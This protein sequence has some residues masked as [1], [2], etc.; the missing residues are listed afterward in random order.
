MEDKTPVPPAPIEIPHDALAPDVLRGIIEEYVTRAGI[1]YEDQ[2]NSLE[3]K[4]Q[5]VLAT[6]LRGQAVILF[7]EETESTTIAPATRKGRI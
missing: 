5:E 1:E 4:Y 6:I 2:D 3:T 7:D